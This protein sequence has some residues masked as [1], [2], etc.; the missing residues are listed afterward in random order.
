M[1]SLTEFFSDI[2]IKNTEKEK[3]RLEDQWNRKWYQPSVLE[4]LVSIYE[5]IS[6]IECEQAHLIALTSFS[7]ILRKFSNASSKYPN[8]MFDKNAPIKGAP[9]KSYISVLTKNI[10]ALIALRKE[11]TPQTFAP[12]IIQGSNLQM[13]LSACSIDAI[14]THP[15]YIAAVP[16]AEYGA[17]SLNWLGFSTKD[18][19]EKL[20]GG[21]R[22]SKNVVDR[23]MD[24]YKK[25]F[26]ECHTVLKSRKYMFLMVGNPTAN[27]SVV[28]LLSASLEF[29][30]IA[31]FS[32][33]KTATRKGSNRRGNKMGEEYLLFFQKN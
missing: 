17:L 7:D 6:S 23:F 13:P 8:V 31:G 24:D 26:H 1:T 28:D 10:E 9:F 25:F 22:H 5:V 21:K 2:S 27:G 29:A 3:W 19:D 12:Q 11:I 32:H 18:I 20:T 33:I 4:K 16:Y 30:K 15:P 14:I